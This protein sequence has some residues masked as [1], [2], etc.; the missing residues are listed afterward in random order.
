[1]SKIEL[2]GRVTR[3]NARL[4]PALI[5]MATSALLG[6]LGPAH[7][8]TSR[9]PVTPEWRDTANRVAQAGVPLADLA[10]NAPDSHTVQPGDTLW[11]ISTLFLKSAWRWP[12]LWGMNLEQIRNPHLIFPGQQLFLEKKDGRATLRMGAAGS[13]APTNT[14]RMSPRVRSSLMDNGAIAAIPMNVIGPFLNEAVVFN[15]NELDKAPRVVATQEGRVMV[16]RGETAYVRGELSG[17]RD[18]RLF[19]QL[20]P[21]LDPI[22]KEV[23]GHEGRYVG[24]AEL[25]KAGGTDGPA[26]IPATFKVTTTRLEAVT[27][28][29]LSPVPQ[30]EFLAYVPRSP[31]GPV[32]GRVVSVYGDGLQAGQNQ[33]VTINRGQREGMERGHVL[34][35]WRA[36]VRSTDKVSGDKAAL[37][38]PDEKHGVLFVFRVFE[39]VSYALILNVQEPVRAGDRFTQP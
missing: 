13:G 3:P 8:Q 17:A 21:L 29:R 15:T 34:A 5:L 12:E 2:Q 11:G 33:V 16:S 18:F 35:L 26:L 27:G 14:V 9:L 30:Q 1:M 32:D 22:T 31:D 38:L 19:R 39:R 7:A 28:D 24:T 10:P 4:R 36:G 37:K 6:S 20:V 25:V 23:L